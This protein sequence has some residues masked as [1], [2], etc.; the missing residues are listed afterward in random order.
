MPRHDLETTEVSA[1]KTEGKKQNAT[2][3]LDRCSKKIPKLTW[4]RYLR[5]T[6]SAQ[7]NALQPTMPR[8]Q[9]KGTYTHSQHM[10]M[11]G[12]EGR[13]PYSIRMGGTDSGGTVN[14]TPGTV[15]GSALVMLRQ[16]RE[17]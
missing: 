17:K 6:H 12:I 2:T 13:C 14:S 16:V 15:D 8:L 4:F 11:V 3:I 7:Q 9:E 10:K 1:H 5:T